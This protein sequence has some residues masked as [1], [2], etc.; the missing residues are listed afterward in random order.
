MFALILGG[1]AN[2]DGKGVPG[3]V[4]RRALQSARQAP[5]LEVGRERA[6][7]GR[8]RLV[9]GCCQGASA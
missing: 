1:F 5:F 2:R 9:L 3:S 8:L 6:G 7:G 4:P